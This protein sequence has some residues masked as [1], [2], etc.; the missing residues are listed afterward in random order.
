LFCFF[1]GWHD[2]ETSGNG[3]SKL[4]GRLAHRVASRPIEEIHPNRT[5]PT[6]QTNAG[7]R[8]LRFR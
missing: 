4:H 5:R 3:N 8:P 1:S 6:E 2:D 7:A